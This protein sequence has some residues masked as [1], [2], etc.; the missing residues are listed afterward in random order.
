MIPYAKQNISK[1]D[2]ESVISV[3]KSDYLTQGPVV[4]EFENEVA[5]YCNSKYAI[6]VNS[7]TSALHISCLALDVKKNDIVWTSSISFVASANC[8]LYCDASIDFIDINPDT[9]NICIDKLELKLKEAKCKN[10]LPKVL[11]AVHMCGQSCEMDKIFDL[12][13]KYNFKIIEDAS[14]SIGGKYKNQPIG[15]CS[16]SDITIFSFHPVK[17]ITSGEGGMIT[18]NN[19]NIANHLRLLRSHGITSNL[20]DFQKHNID[21]I[22]N[23]EQ[24]DLGYNYRMTDI[25]AALGLSQFSKLD[26]F[27]QERNEIANRYDNLLNNFP[28]LLPRVIK[29]SYSAFHLYIIRI[30]HDKC[31]KTNKDIYKILHQNGIKVNFHYIPIYRQPYYQNLGYKFD[32]FPSAELHF[33]QSLSLPIFSGLTLED[34]NYVINQLEKALIN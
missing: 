23:Y 14:H 30:N 26:V 3:L 12:S 29:N 4:P 13:K 7:A 33:K 22:W 11:I 16:Y 31:T 19:V 21:E 2:I 6:A 27:V 8:A 25:A 17:I 20:E 32:S 34:Q 10:K 15:N 1:E 9:F 24:V 28:I 18:T 5:K